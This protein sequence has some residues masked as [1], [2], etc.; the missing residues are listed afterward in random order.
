MTILYVNGDSHSAGH[1][2]GGPEFSYG[3]HVADALGAEFV[4]EAVPACSNDSIISRTMKYIE[5]NHPD[6][7]IIGWSTWERETWWYYD[8]SYH[9]TA[10]GTDTVHPALVDKYK[11]WVIDSCSPEF[12]N[13]VEERNHENI[14]CLHQVLLDKKIKHLFFNCYSHFFYTVAHNKTRHNWGNNYI[15][16]Y[17]RNS[18]YYHWL[19]NNGYQPA[20]PKFYHYGPDAHE[21]WA[22]FL[23]DHIDKL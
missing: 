23:L 1:D 15:D 19:Q 4:C 22:K 9:I 11:Q 12:Q 16:P 14:W 6:L 7:L 8:Q 10:S 21:A 2:A 17:D 3:R 18:A 13:R 20:N 5:N